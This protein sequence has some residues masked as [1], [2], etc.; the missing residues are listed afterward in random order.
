MSANHQYY[1]G[2]FWPNSAGHCLAGFDPKQTMVMKTASNPLLS[3]AR[4]FGYLVRSS[5]LLCGDRL[6]T[7]NQPMKESPRCSPVKHIAHSIHCEKLKGYVMPALLKKCRVKIAA[8]A[9][10]GRA[11]HHLRSSL[12]VIFPYQTNVLFGIAIPIDATYP[13]QKGHRQ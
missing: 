9:P 13:I 1:T 3:W 11:N 2:C 12:D 5:A 4:R 7:R 6:R 10:T 8:R